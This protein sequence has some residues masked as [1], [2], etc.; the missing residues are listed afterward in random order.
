MTLIT[1]DPG[2]W[3][4]NLFIA[5]GKGN[6]DLLPPYMSGWVTAKRQIEHTFSHFHLVLDLHQTDEVFDDLPVHDGDWRWV[7]RHDLA[8]EALPTAMKKVAVAML[9]SDVFRTVRPDPAIIQPSSDRVHWFYMSASRVLQSAGGSHDHL[10]ILL[11]TFF[12]GKLQVRSPIIRQ[13]S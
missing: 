7:A 9:G 13:M 4:C 3:P 8:A 11:V 2:F 1:T 6:T 12:H 10:Q 5:T